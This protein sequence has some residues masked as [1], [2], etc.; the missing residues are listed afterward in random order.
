MNRAD[1][2]SQ[3][4]TTPESLSEQPSAAEAASVAESDAESTADVSAPGENTESSGP[5][6]LENR[7]G[8]TWARLRENR[9]EVSAAI[10]LA[11][12]AFLWFDSGGAGSG[13][14]ASIPDPLDGYDAVLS[15]FESP[16]D[17]EQLRDS[18]EPQEIAAPTVFGSDSLYIPQYD[19]SVSATGSSGRV[20]DPAPGAVARYSNE[21]P[22]FNSSPVRGLN[23]PE[24]RKIK[25]AGQIQPV[26]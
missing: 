11:V 19:A 1:L 7:F 25:F 17:A 12:M 13:D 14:A 26:N 2:E 9:R 20:A 15:E 8:V 4:K 16:Q 24:R 18:A 10:V 21:T 3:A 6:W 5:T 23:K 22:A